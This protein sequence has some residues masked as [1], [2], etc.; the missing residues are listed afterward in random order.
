MDRIGRGQLTT[1]Q[2]Q[3]DGLL[4]IIEAIIDTDV[5]RSIG[6]FLKMGVLVSTDPADLDKVRHQVAE[7]Y[8]TGKV[9]AN[10]KKLRRGDTNS[11]TT[12]RTTMAATVRL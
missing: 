9:K 11:K 4:D 10:R 5:D 1:R 6:A 7:H 2:G 12:T 8:R 3:A